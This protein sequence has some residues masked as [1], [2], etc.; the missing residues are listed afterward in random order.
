MPTYEYVCTS[1]A[2]A[3]EEVQ[4]ISADALTDCPKCHQATAKRQISAGNFIL[5]GGGWYADLYSSTKK[6]SGSSESKE[7]KGGESAATASSSESKSS[8]SKS[9]ESKSSSGGESSGGGESKA[10][11]APAAEAERRR[12]EVVRAAA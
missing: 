2:N 12:L 6:S 11:P 8:E 9:S 4:K 3:W 10:A 5:K 1:C 7:S